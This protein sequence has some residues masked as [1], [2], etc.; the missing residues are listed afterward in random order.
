MS[1]GQQGWPD[2]CHP[3]S[4]S[5]PPRY[6]SACPLVLS[7]QPPLL[8]TKTCSYKTPGEGRRSTVTV[9]SCSLRSM[10]LYPGH[11]KAGSPDHHSPSPLHSP[12]HQRDSKPNLMGEAEVWWPEAGSF[13]LRVHTVAEDRV[14]RLIL[15]WRPELR[16]CLLRV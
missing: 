15:T 12:S 14:K 5:P 4:L 8:V 13:N 16:F 7:Q 1:L 3:G 10:W 11:L 6:P 2:S 9:L